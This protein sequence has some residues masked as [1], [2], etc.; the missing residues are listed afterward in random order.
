LLL[1]LLLLQLLTPL[2]PILLVMLL[3][4]WVQAVQHRF[5]VLTTRTGPHSLMASLSTQSQSA[6]CLWQAVQ[7]CPLRTPVQHCRGEALVSL[8]LVL[9]LLLLYLLTALIMV[10][11]VLL[12]LR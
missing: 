6:R 1:V 7:R 3:L 2:V 9:V 4:R 8:W 12:V 10:Q 11:L 5:A